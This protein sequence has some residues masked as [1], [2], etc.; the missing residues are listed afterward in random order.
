MEKKSLLM[1]VGLLFSTILFGQ[2]GVN[3]TTPHATLDVVAKTTDGSTPEGII[4][5]RLTGNALSDASLATTPPYD[6]NQNGAIVYVTAAADA[7][8]QAGQTTLVDAPGYYYFNATDNQWKKLKENIYN[9]NGILTSQR[10]MDMNNNTL[11]FLNGRVSM[12]TN[13]SHPSSILELKSITQG[14]L[15]PRMTQAQM[16]AIVN[17]ALALMIYCTDCYAGN[18]G[19]LMINDSPIEG[20]PKWGS[21]CSTN[22][23]APSVLAL[24]CASAT[25]SGTVNSGQPAS[26]VSTTVPYTGGNGAVYQAAN[27]GSTGVTGLT[28][29]LPS[30]SLANGNGNLVFNITGTASAAGTASFA[31]T[32]AG[33]SC[34]FTVTVTTSTA[35]VSTLN[36]GSATFSPTTLTQGTLYSGTLTVPYTGGNGAAYSQSTITQNGLT[37]T[38]PA[39]ILLSGNGSLNYSVSGTPTTAGSMSIPISFGGVSCSV[40][41]T[42][43]TSTTVV[44]PGNPQPWSRINLGGNTSLNPDVP[45]QAIHGNYYQWGRAGAVAD[46]STPSANIAGWDNSAAALGSWTDATKTIND[47]CPT[48]FRVPTGQQFTN[49]INNTTRSGVGTFTE[50]ETNY[51]S[52]IVFSG[53]GNKLTFPTAGYRYTT[54]GYLRFRGFSGYYWT[55]T[56]TANATAMLANSTSATVYNTFYRP[57]GFSIRCISQ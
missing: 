41:T 12:G 42:V 14:F 31:I 43:G 6:I 32:V 21:L 27:F 37:F 20:S 39:G 48:G 7:S 51:G 45:V 13:I 8:N 30:G 49:L 33:K 23:V 57:N 47:P 2:I 50:S 26:G 40:S 9:I 56:A 19:C 54:G 55:S 34:S 3:T 28:A 44:M 10:I 15:P 11:G 36:C 1:M 4:A 38:L 52:A 29:N 25:T 35:T 18:S 5:P 53:G 24:N 16:N 22:A 17:P 46:A